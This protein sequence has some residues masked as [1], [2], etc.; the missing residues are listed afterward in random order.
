[1]SRTFS[2]RNHLKR[3]GV[4]TEEGLKKHLSFILK[5]LS[6][7][8]NLDLRSYRVSRLSPNEVDMS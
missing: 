7:N 5:T 6:L 3:Q 8:P 4:D 1:M 2:I